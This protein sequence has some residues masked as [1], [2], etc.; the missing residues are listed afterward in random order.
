M[1]IDITLGQCSILLTCGLLLQFE[2]QRKIVFSEGC[3]SGGLGGPGKDFEGG[4]SF[5]NTSCPKMLI[6]PIN[7]LDCAV[8]IAIYETLVI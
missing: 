5:A 8:P 6:R 4:Q 3:G 7:F 1:K 2:S